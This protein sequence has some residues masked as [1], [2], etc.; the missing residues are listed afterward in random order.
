MRTALRSQGWDQE[1]EQIIKY[2]IRKDKV[3]CADFRLTA[4]QVYLKLWQEL[5]EQDPILLLMETGVRIS[6]IL[7]LY[8]SARS[9]NEC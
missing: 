3:S 2:N 5:T 9:P 4:I 8:A 1:C 6:D 7:C